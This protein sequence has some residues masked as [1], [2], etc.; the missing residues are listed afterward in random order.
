M[1]EGLDVCRRIALGSGEYLCCIV[2][3]ILKDTPTISGV[4][5]LF[6]LGDSKKHCI[7][8]TLVF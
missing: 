6:F 8:Y 7:F 1:S 3:L 4:A 5:H 2:A